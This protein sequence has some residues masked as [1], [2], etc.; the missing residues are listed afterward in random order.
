M[1][2]CCYEIAGRVFYS[3]AE[4]DSISF[5]FTSG[6]KAEFRQ[7]ING[8]RPIING[9]LVRWEIRAEVDSSY[10]SFRKYMD[11]VF[12]YAGSYSLSKE[13]Q[14][15]HNIKDIQIGDVFIKGGFPGHA[16]I[17]RILL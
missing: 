7:W 15:V 9:S 3:R 11:I 10:K 16:V 12:T 1:R 5:N 13:M 17:V 4:Y 14:A 2:R 6:D 8:Y